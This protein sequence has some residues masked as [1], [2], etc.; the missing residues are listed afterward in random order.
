L[1]S[2]AA[3]KPHEASPIRKLS[4]TG[5]SIPDRSPEAA[6]RLRELVASLR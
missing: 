2:A 4:E 5:S 3:A 6:T 1:L